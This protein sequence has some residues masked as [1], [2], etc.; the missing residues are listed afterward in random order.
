M[1]AY[2]LALIPFLVVVF[3]L[4]DSILTDPTEDPDE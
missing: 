1:T 3:L 2:W 4:C